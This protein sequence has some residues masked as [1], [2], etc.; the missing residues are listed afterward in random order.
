MNIL[1]R[2]LS[3]IGVRI[4]TRPSVHVGMVHNDVLL[5]LMLIKLS[6]CL[7]VSVSV[8]Q[9]QCLSLSFSLSVSVSQCPSLSLSYIF[10]DV[11]V[12]TIT[13]LRT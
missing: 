10:K 4:P 12:L 1:C 5:P 3:S 7:S 6:L 11:K 8:S 2:H 13:F 9:F